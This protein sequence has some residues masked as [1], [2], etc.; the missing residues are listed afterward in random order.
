MSVKDI[1]IKNETYFFFNDIINIKD[2]Q[3]NN[4]EIDEKSYNNILINYIGYETIK[5]DH[6]IY[7]VN[8]IYLSFYKIDEYF[9]DINGNNYL[10]LV[11]TN[12]SKK[13]MKNM[14]NCDVKS[15]I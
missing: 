10:T 9:E 4:T 3:P 5:K 13:N 8:P 7:I 1:S 12:E 6:K 14:K 11:T 15:E 2:F